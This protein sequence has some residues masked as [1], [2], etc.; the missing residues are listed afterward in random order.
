MHKELSAKKYSLFTFNLSFD[1]DVFEGLIESLFFYMRKFY[2]V[3]L[4]KKKPLSR[5]F[6]IA[7]SEQQADD[8][9]KDNSLLDMQSSTTLNC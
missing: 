3:C 6:F 2:A 5:Y 1:P 7:D 4:N 8:T 9:S